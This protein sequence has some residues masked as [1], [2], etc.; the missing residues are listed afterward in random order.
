MIVGDDDSILVT[1]DKIK[2]LKLRERNPFIYTA[3]E[4]KDKKFAPDANKLLKIISYDDNDPIE[5]NRF[6]DQV[7]QEQ[8]L[9]FD[10][11]SV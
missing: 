7:I 9:N 6:V 11:E 2:I 4:I 3:E 10:F 8:D 5:L 1:A